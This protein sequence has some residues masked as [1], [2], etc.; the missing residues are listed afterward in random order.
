M[1]L[2]TPEEVLGLA[3]SPDDAIDVS[4]IRVYRIEAAQLRYI[5]PVF[6]D[7]MYQ[8]MILERHADFVFTYIRPAL[9]HYIRYEMIG[10][11][12]V[13]AS[14]RGV[15][16]ASSEESTQTTSA[17]KNEQQD[18][19]DTER[20]ELSGTQVVE[21]TSSGTTERVTTTQSNGEQ[22]SDGSEITETTTQRTIN[23]TDSD[24]VST[25]T[26]TTEQVDEALAATV[27]SSS[28]VEQTSGSVKTTD[29]TTESEEV[30]TQ[31][32]K[33]DTSTVSETVNGT[34]SGSETTNSEQS[35]VT[36]VDTTVELSASTEN[37]GTGTTSQQTA[38]AASAYEWMLMARQAL[39]DAR[40]FLRVAVEYVEAHPDEFPDYEPRI[41]RGKHRLRRCMGGVIL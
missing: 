33:T 5:R 7:K 22:T 24:R 15:V 28:T 20:R 21:K 3:F 26:D 35:D 10:E 34:E 39:R 2:I 32:V 1:Q 12:A 11:L 27:G 40:L 30:T 14:D 13:R 38:K 8:Q 16:R 18:R 6:G 25:D 31:A 41:K 19:T 17:T 9:A 37:S 4:H 29:E 36:T 23:E